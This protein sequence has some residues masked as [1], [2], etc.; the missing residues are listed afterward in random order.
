MLTRRDML[1]LAGA[2]VAA[3]ATA[4]ATTMEAMA[5]AAASP[6]D[7]ACGIATRSPAPPTDASRMPPAIAETIPQANGSALSNSSAISNGSAVSLRRMGATP[8][9]Y[10][11]RGRTA[12]FDIV[13]HTH[14][15]GLG[16][17]QTSLP[18]ATTPEE[19]RAFRARLERHDMR[20]VLGVRLPYD[21]AE[22]PAFDTAVARAKEAGAVCLHAAMTG[23]RYEEFDSLAAF[24][25]GLARHRQAVALAEPVLRRHRV[26]LAIEN[27]KGWRAAEQAAWLTG[28]GSEF[29]GVCFDFG[30][31]LSLCEDP[32]E[33]LRL[34]APLTRYC[35]LK[36]MAVEAVDEGFLLSEVPLGDGILDL[37]GMVSTLQARQPE[38]ILGLEMITRD[39]L[40]IPV[41]T[42]RYW[43]TF[44]D[45]SSPLPGRDLARTLVLVKQ[46]PPARPLPRTT[47]LSPAAQVSL[48]DDCIA[49]S[50][51]FAQRRLSL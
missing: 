46:H 31:N 39:P 48:E 14:A 7:A 16:A 20:A 49:R 4:R 27:H 17:V 32:Q 29:V 9:G 21:R 22:L 44:D 33:T 12:G 24:Q 19:A 18:A 36:D 30:N 28:V 38:L 43:L 13:D 1:R 34:L 42:D 41:F 6:L 11:C 37:A 10:A 25:A 35:H 40:R 45:S 15:L 2:G 5:A 50:L 8:A 26:V 51:Q 47:G 3:T 23:R